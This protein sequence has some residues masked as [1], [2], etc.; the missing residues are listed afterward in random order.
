M[1]QIYRGD[2]PVRTAVES[3]EEV[4][5]RN[6]LCIECNRL[7]STIKMTLHGRGSRIMS[8]VETFPGLNSHIDV[9]VVSAFDLFR[10]H[11]SRMF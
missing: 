3:E 5:V 6:A 10:L 4:E 8:Q 1:R 2:P 9:A 7:G 11:F